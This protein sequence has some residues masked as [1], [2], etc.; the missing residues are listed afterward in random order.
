MIQIISIHYFSGSN[1]K[2]SNLIFSNPV[3]RIGYGIMEILTFLI[4]LFTDDV[5]K[6]LRSWKALLV[7]VS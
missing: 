3:V 2:P 5:Q 4:P 6:L 1:I 7:I